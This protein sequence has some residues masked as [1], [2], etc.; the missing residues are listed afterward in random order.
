MFRGAAEKTNRCELNDY[1]KDV[2]VF[3]KDWAILS[4]RCGNCSSTDTTFWGQLPFPSFLALPWLMDTLWLGSGIWILVDILCLLQKMPSLKIRPV[5]G[6]KGPREYSRKLLWLV[7]SP[8][9]SDSILNCTRVLCPVY[10]MKPKT[11]D[12]QTCLEK[13]LEKGELS[14]KAGWEGRDGVF[15]DWT[16]YHEFLVVEPKASVPVMVCLPNERILL[17]SG[18]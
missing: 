18:F 6:K 7:L 5:S 3:F 11:S 1:L 17:L 2:C 14:W 15:V 10:E 16:K 8:W 9:G 4:E 13:S 12:L